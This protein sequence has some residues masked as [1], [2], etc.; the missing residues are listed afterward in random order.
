[1]LEAV[2]NA[3]EIMKKRVS[4]RKPDNNYT[5]RSKSWFDLD[6]KTLRKNS[7]RA[8]RNFRIAKTLDALDIYK[9][10]KA[11]YKA[12]I[13]VKKDLYFE[14]KSDL[15]SDAANDK[16]PK[17]FWNLLKAERKPLSSAI[18][19][20][21]WFRHFSELLN[22]PLPTDIENGNYIE[23]EE[24][25][26]LQNEYLD[27][28]ISENEVLVAIK[29]LKTGKSPGIDGLISQFFKSCPEQ[30]C[31]YLTT[32][33]NSYFEHGYFPPEWSSSIISPIH[34]KGNENDQKN[35]RGVSLLSE[36]SKIFT[37]II[38]TRLKIWCETN[39]VLG[40]EQAGFRKQH[41]TIDDVFCLH[42][43]ITKYL[44]H[45][46][47]RF[48][49]LFVDFE[50]A[51]D[52]VDRLLL[53]QKLFTQ[54][55]STK[56]VRMLKAIYA[57]VRAYIRTSKG[58]TNTVPCPVGVRQGCIIS[59]IIFTLFL[60]DLQEYI[61]VGSHGIDIETIKL[62]VL[63]FA[64]D[65]VIFA[66]TVI[67]L[68]RLINRLVGYCDRWRMKVNL[69]KTKVV[70]FRNGGPLRRYEKWK[71]DDFKLEVVTYYKYLGLLLSSRN[72]WYMCQ[73]TLASQA[74]KALFS[75]KKNLIRFGDVKVNILLKIFDSKIFP[76][77]L[78]GS[79]IWFSHISPDIEQVHT[80]FCK[81]ILNLPIQSPNCF[82]KSELGRYSVTLYRNL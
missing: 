31:P 42:T 59:L 43:L 46:G 63:L 68:Q 27:R 33:F 28:P 22:P 35:Y 15:L 80:K 45:K 60:N 69:L 8:L 66:E 11:D 50:K 10:I 57:D 76:I 39:N 5:R 24:Q 61:S 14:Y 73:K 30:I 4:N 38:N 19:P 53:W 9:H 47:G 29:N 2:Y 54:N 25:P 67:E 75:V 12:M 6:C 34:K 49:A 64:D 70:V 52:H 58:L 16:N 41:T 40:E 55:V 65:L 17:A 3:A 13:K 37:S 72:S 74:S 36:M 79:E 81:F 23:D 7:I 20:N 62:F 78:Y 1:M 77:L 48:Y 18:K 21:D 32:L 56:M 51:F 26:L 82:V 44:R 71:F